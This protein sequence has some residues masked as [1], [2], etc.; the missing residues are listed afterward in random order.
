MYSGLSSLNMFG[1][2]SII[3]A[4]R[5]MIKSVCLLYMD[6]AHNNKSGCNPLPCVIRIPR[7]NDNMS[8]IYVC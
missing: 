2:A 7:R 3:P 1:I 6:K 8:D 5:Y 4:T